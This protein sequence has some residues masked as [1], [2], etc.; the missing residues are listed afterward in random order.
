M[1][2]VVSYLESKE[3]I[4]HGAVIMMALY[5][6]H[7]GSLFMRLEHIDMSL[8]GFSLFNWIYGIALA[9]IIEFLIL[10]FIING[11][12]DTGKF[13]AVVSFFINAFY[14]DYWFQAYL[15]PDAASIKLMSISLIICL[16]HSIAVWQLHSYLKQTKPN[17]VLSWAFSCKDI[18]KS[19]TSSVSPSTSDSDTISP[20]L[21]EYF[22]R[23]LFPQVGQDKCQ[24]F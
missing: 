7:A 2:K 20:Y 17:F 14:Y 10:L 23:N 12:R 1:N 4:F 16:V 18:V 6:P 5:V 15:K 19:S 24:L 13:Y 9:G 21:P 11:Y 8:A 3:A 22:S